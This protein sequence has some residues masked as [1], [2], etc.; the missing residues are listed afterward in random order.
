MRIALVLSSASAPAVPLRWRCAQPGSAFALISTPCLFGLGPQ[1]GDHP[2]R[3]AAEKPP[4]LRVAAD[5]LGV[6]AQ[7]MN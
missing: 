7:S 1:G 6:D 2:R 4:R 3:V 5:D